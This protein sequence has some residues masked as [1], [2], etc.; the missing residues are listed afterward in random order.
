MSLDAAVCDLECYVINHANSMFSKQH[1][2]GK[3]KRKFSLKGSF[4]IG[5]G[6]TQPGNIQHI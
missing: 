5:R 6:S 2:D 3:Q 4:K 1:R